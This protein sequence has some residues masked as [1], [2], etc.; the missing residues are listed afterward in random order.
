MS[1]KRK[2]IAAGI[3]LT[4]IIAL[5]MILMAL[6]VNVTVSYQDEDNGGPPTGTTTIIATSTTPDDICRTQCGRTMTTVIE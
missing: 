4:I 6:I 3:Y 2:D 5:F 1:Q